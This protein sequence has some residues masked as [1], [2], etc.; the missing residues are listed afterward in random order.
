MEWGFFLLSTKAGGTT[1]I[2][3]RA[4]GSEELL[5]GRKL[6]EEARDEGT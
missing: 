5:R 4:A 2:G 6:K 3:F 1:P